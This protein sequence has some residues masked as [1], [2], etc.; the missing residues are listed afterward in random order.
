MPNE[1][2]ANTLLEAMSLATDRTAP[3]V[4]SDEYKKI[5]EVAAPA[6]VW[7]VWVPIFNQFG[8]RGPN[9]DNHITRLRVS[10]SVVSETKSTFD[11]EIKG[12]DELV[13]DVGP[14]SSIVTISGNV[15]TSIMLRAKSH[16]IVGLSIDVNVR[17]F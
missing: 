11:V 5:G 15:A 13:T 10:Y 9:A 16:S 12:G 17:Q 8:V 1:F 2:R 3:I 4:P 7:G 6:L 14:S